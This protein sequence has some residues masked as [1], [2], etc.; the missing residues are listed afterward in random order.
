MKQ[1]TQTEISATDRKEIKPY[2]LQRSVT[3]LMLTS[4]AKASGQLWRFT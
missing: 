3:A 4:Y 2:E 1:S